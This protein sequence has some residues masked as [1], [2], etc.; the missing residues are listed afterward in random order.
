MEAKT[1]ATWTELTNASSSELRAA[2]RGTGALAECA[3]R[4]LER[5]EKAEASLRSALG[6]K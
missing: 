2:A 5:R 1:A 4:E 6:W 3:R